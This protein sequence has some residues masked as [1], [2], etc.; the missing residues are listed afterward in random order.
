MTLVTVG[1]CRFVP[2]LAL[3]SANQ[4]LREREHLTNADIAR[5]S[6]LGVL[7]V[8]KLRRAL[9]QEAAA[10]EEMPR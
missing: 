7:T 2:S 1:L 3:I 9:Q 4:L 8:R 10:A 6:G 5:L